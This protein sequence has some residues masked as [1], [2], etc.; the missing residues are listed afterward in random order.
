MRELLR[1]LLCLHAYEVVSRTR[2]YGDE[3][4]DYYWQY[5]LMCRKCGK[6]KWRY[7]G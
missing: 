3:R 7:C 5:K 2:S 4:L 1:R 6:T